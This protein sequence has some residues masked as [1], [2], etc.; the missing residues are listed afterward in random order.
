MDESVNDMPLAPPTRGELC[1]CAIGLCQ[2]R[3]SAYCR[4]YPPASAS[5]ETS[6]A[7]A[8]P[9]AEAADD[10]AARLGRP[11]LAPPTVPELLERAAAKYRERNAQYGNNYKNFGPILMALF[12]EGISI[13]DAHDANRFGVLIQ[14]IAKLSRYAVNFGVGGHQDSI[15]DLQVYAA[16][17]EE[18]DASIPF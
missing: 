4:A 9:F 17:L 2:S 6:E 5:L 13:K 11:D 1:N 3:G 7:E 8:R 16:M 12:P 14:I 10:F 15:H 18:L